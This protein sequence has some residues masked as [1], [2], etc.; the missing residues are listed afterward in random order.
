MTDG[1]TLPPPASKWRSKSGRFGRDSR[2]SDDGSSKEGGVLI[3]L[4]AGCHYDRHQQVRWISTRGPPP[5]EATAASVSD[6]KLRKNVGVSGLALSVPFTY[7]LALGTLVKAS[8]VSRAGRCCLYR[9]AQRH[10]ADLLRLR[11]PCILNMPYVDAVIAAVEAKLLA[12]TVEVLAFSR[13]LCLVPDFLQCRSHQPLS[14]PGV[15]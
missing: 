5:E 10:A 12:G 2:L 13:K 15:A 3:T 8:R 7:H 14:G 11:R 9:K 1:I 6:L 4:P